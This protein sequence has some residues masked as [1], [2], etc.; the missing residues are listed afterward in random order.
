MEPVKLFVELPPEVERYLAQH[1]TSLG[2]LLQQQ[3]I[4]VRE[5]HERHPFKTIEGNAAQRDIGLVL[6]SAAGAQR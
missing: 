1:R 4:I 2:Q 3:G 5:S 6:A